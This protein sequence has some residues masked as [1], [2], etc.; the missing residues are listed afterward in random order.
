[1]YLI[2]DLPEQTLI[3]HNW[4][5]DNLQQMPEGKCHQLKSRDDAG[6]PA[7]S[8][9]DATPRIVSVIMNWTAGQ[10]LALVEEYH[11]VPTRL[12]MITSSMIIIATN[13]LKRTCCRLKGGSGLGSGLG[14]GSGCLILGE[15]HK[16]WRSGLWPHT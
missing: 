7:L 12:M 4:I 3:A 16:A 1:L 11:G 15:F 14:S 6:I 10:A 2:E 13:S 9:I 5:A 8:A